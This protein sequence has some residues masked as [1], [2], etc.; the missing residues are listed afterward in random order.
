MPRLSDGGTIVFDDHGFRHCV[1]AKVA[2]QGSFQELARP[3]VL[4]PTG[5]AVYFHAN[6]PASYSS[7]DAVS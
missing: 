3:I 2:I 6:I 1:V 5:Q 7:E 4:L